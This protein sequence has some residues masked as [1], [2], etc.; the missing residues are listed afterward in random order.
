MKAATQRRKEATQRRKTGIENKILDYLISI[1][2]PKS[3]RVA[4]AATNVAHEVGSAP[5][6][7]RTVLAGMVH[8]GVLAQISDVKRGN[9]TVYRVLAMTRGDVITHYETPIITQEEVDKLSAAPSV[10]VVEETA[11]AE[12]VE[13][14]KKYHEWKAHQEKFKAA[15][16][17]ALFEPRV[18]CTNTID[19]LYMAKEALRS[20]DYVVSQMV[21]NFLRTRRA[22]EDLVKEVENGR[23]R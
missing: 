21:E 19:A 7:V 4:I 23:H 15:G 2:D 11:D 6:T 8:D 18:S 12:S 22:L 9:P 20:T 16:V 3:G 10:E 13:V 1:A 14:Q 17:E 5:A